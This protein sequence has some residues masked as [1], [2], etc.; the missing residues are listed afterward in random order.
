MVQ[1]DDK[2][3]HIVK[4]LIPLTRLFL[5]NII[6]IQYYIHVELIAA[7]FVEMKYFMVFRSMS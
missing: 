3:K 6:K 4:P 1:C 7:N 2:V 5:E